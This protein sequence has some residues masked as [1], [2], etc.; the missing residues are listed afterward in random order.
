M[1]CE[2]S[3]QEKGTT[4][5]FPKP[6]AWYY[7][8]GA[9]TC[10]ATETFLFWTQLNG[11]KVGL[12]T[13]PFSQ[14]LYLQTLARTLQLRRFHTFSLRP[15]KINSVEVHMW[16]LTGYFSDHECSLWDAWPRWND[17]L[18]NS[19]CTAEHPCVVQNEGFGLSINSRW[20]YFYEVCQYSNCWVFK[21]SVLKPPCH[22]RTR[23]I[24]TFNTSSI[25]IYN[26]T[27]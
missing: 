4:T 1:V 24:K 13:A 21:K 2:V 11:C 9:G 15:R 5:P 7:I 12:S 20:H 25:A 8:C 18:T 16:H 10:R 27:H 6:P 17:E 3:C 22:H 26:Q 23:I 14:L 19:K